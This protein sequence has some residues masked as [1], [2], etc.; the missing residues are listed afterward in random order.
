MLICGLA[1]ISLADEEDAIAALHV[2][3]V[4]KLL[5][6][7]STTVRRAQWRIIS[8]TDLRLASTLLQKPLLDYRMQHT[9]TQVPAKLLMAAELHTA[10]TMDAV[11]GCGM[12]IFG[13]EAEDLLL[14]LHVQSEAYTSGNCVFS[15][16]NDALEVMQGVPYKTMYSLSVLVA[17]QVKTPFSPAQAILLAMRIYAWSCVP[18]RG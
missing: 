8:W 3:A 6:T 4:R 1:R 14:E 11:Q 13:Q 9:K 15:S 17:E 5:A 2:D 7:N 18:V 16:T 12:D 10:K